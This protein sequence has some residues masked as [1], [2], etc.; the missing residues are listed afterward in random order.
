MN[1]LLTEA[2]AAH[3]GNTRW[4]ELTQARATLVSA[5]HLFTAKGMPQ[6]P[7]PREMTVLLH[8]EHASGRPFGAPD[9]KTD[10][11]PG[12]VGIDKLD[13]RVVAEQGLAFSF[14]CGI[15]GS[16][17]RVQS[18]SRRTL[19]ARQDTHR[20]RCRPHRAASAADLTTKPHRSIPVRLRRLT[21]PHRGPVRR[22][23]GGASPYHS[24]ITPRS[25]TGQP[26]T[27]Q[28]ALTCHFMPALD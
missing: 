26:L 17:R 1:E 4:R 8:E 9:Q 3:G 22:G 6:D 18:Q 10:F 2:I 21:A 13:G 28:E 25:P 24:P 16:S 7:A 15:H 14:A 23:P 20:M 27:N 12:R 5:G 19:E 11:T